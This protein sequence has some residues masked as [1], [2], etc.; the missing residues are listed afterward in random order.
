MVNYFFNNTAIAERA[1]NA[2]NFADQVVEALRQENWQ[3]NAV[4]MGQA[5]ELDDLHL[6]YQTILEENDPKIKYLRYNNIHADQWFKSAKGTAIREANNKIKK[7][8][9]AE[10]PGSKVP[11]QDAPHLSE[12]ADNLIVARFG[13]ETGQQHTQSDPMI[14]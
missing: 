7:D 11:P 10:R 9:S 2:P 3:V 8:K 14:L 6:L 4:Y 5:M 1:D 13:K 12:A